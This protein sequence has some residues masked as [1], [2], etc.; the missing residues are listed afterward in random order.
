MHK[1]NEWEVTLENAPLGYFRQLQDMMYEDG[2]IPSSNYRLDDFSNVDTLYNSTGW[3]WEARKLSDG[4]Y[5]ASSDYTLEDDGSTIPNEWVSRNF[6]IALI[7]AW[8]CRKGVMRP[9]A[10]FVTIDDVAAAHGVSRDAVKAAYKAGKFPGAFNTHP[11]NPRRGEV[12]IPIADK[13]AWQPRN[14]PRR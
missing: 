4:G 8:L 11:D 1:Q 10:S 2:L 13:E 6:N 5:I 9:V 3:A 14:Y 12:R 7:G